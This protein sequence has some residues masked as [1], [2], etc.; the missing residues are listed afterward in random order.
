MPKD[1]TSVRHERLSKISAENKMQAKG[2]Y[3]SERAL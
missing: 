3:D 2:E 1:M